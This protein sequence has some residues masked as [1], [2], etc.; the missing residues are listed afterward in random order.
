M[1]EDADVTGTEP[2][3]RGRATWC[4][5]RRLSQ[6]VSAVALGLAVALP[7]TVAADQPAGAPVKVAIIVGPVGAE[8]TPVYLELAEL[9]ATAATERGASVARAYSP[10]ATAEAV[11]AAVEDANIVVYFGHG[12]GDP[13]PY[14]THPSPSVVNGWGL[15]GARPDANHGDSVAAGQLAYHGEA[16]IAEHAR[17]APGWV[18]I[19]SNAC[20]AP[21][22]GE[23]QFPPADEATAADRVSAYSRVPLGH[24]GASAYF[25]TDF[26]AGAAQLV[27][28]LLD[29]PDATYAAI[30]GAE[31]HYQP[32]AIARHPHASLERTSVWL[33]YSAYFA[34][35]VDYWYAFAGD[36]DATFGSGRGGSLTLERAWRQGRAVPASGQLIV[37]AAAYAGTEAEP[38]VL[39]ADG[40]R[41]ALPAGETSLSVCAERCASLSLA[42]RLP[43]SSTPRAVGVGPAAVVALNPAAWLAVSDQ[44]LGAG[45][46][47]VRIALWPP[48]PLPPASRS[49]SPAPAAASPPASAP[50]AVQPPAP[51]AP[52]PPPPPSPTSIPTPTPSA[53][54]ASPSPTPTRS[55]TPSPSVAPSVSE[56]ASPSASPSLGPSATP[57]PQ[58]SPPAPS[59]SPSAT[60]EPSP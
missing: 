60:P 41:A 17:P 54:S 36:P 9:A 15:N 14:S 7:A 51:P 37:P 20:Y 8:L 58:P 29:A 25:A 40:L 22:A 27:S 3:R 21:G 48:P 50:G 23:G 18:M 53:A 56:P 24:L 39:L 52:P 12:I 47:L 16:W 59:G 42:G 35:A 49:T 33:Q 2:R 11:L 10:N 43:T 38:A 19:Y 5:S 6:L 30:F 44:P 46:L 57:T 28:A 55:P 45:P 32:D 13:N 34:G 1:T 26:Y 31:P 4:S